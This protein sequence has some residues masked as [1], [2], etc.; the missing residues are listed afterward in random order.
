MGS[1]RLDA[2]TAGSATGLRIYTKK[3][4]QSLAGKLSYR[5]RTLRHKAELIALD[6]PGRIFSPSPRG[7]SR[8][9][10]Q[11]AHLRH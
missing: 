4:F 5:S 3:I 8:G 1:R 11:P 7:E 2:E 10:V 9:P 6:S